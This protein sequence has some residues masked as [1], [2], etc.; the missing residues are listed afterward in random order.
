[1]IS[2]ISKKYASRPNVH[3][4]GR[5]FASLLV[6]KRGKPKGEALPP[7]CRLVQKN[8]SLYGLNGFSYSTNYN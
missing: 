6:Y 4:V 2:N 3:E 5:L 1:M 8:G 7:P